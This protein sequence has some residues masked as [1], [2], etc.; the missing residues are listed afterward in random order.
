[1]VDLVDILKNAPIGLNLWSDVYG[2]VELES[3]YDHSNMIFPICVAYHYDGS[4]VQINCTR[5]GAYIIGPRNL[6]V[7]P[8]TLWPNI[9]RNWNNWQSQL[10]HKGDII[11]YESNDFRKPSKTY[12]IVDTDGGSDYK[13]TLIDEK[14]KVKHFSY[15]YLIHTRYATDQ[16]ELD[17]KTALEE[18]G[19]IIDSHRNVV[20][21][22][23]KPY[24][25]PESF[26]TPFGSDYDLDEA[27]E[28]SLNKNENY[29]TRNIVLREEL[30]NIIV[31]L[32]K[33]KRLLL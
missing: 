9:D 19:Y 28:N 30:D 33:L 2:E 4:K 27:I 8:C 1:M 14:G 10:M 6:D 21:K 26:R 15:L 22:P 25:K 31:S 3:S 18:N 16:E 32:N 12:I 5:K 17:F 29:K 11:T 24:V 23:R 13:F 7:Y 20:K